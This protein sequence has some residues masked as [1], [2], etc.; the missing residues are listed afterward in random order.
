MPM[1][2]FAKTEWPSGPPTT[3]QAFAGRYPAHEAYVSAVRAAANDSRPSAS[4]G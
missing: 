1:I 2:P 3:T 4:A